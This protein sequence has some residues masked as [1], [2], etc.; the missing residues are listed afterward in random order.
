MPP[1]STTS[2]KVFN[3]RMGTVR[4]RAELPPRKVQIWCRSAQLW[5]LDLNP[6]PKVETQ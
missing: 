3:I 2:P 5:A 1:G 6:V 4:Q